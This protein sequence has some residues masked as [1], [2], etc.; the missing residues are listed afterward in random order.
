MATKKK[1]NAGRKELPPG[2]RLA[3]VT[4]YVKTKNTGAARAE[5]LRIQA[6]YR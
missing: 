2:E 1:S 3:P 4:I 6:K 5:C